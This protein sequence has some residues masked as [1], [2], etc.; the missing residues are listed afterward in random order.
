MSELGPD[1]PPTSINFNNLL[2]CFFFNVFYTDYIGIRWI[3][4]VK[5]YLQ[6]KIEFQYLAS[7][8]YCE[9]ID[10]NKKIKYKN[11]CGLTG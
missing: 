10:C 6:L 4:R 11:K 9:E 8:G 2:K 1:T 3:H 7:L 5:Q